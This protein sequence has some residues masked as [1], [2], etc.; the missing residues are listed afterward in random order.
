MTVTSCVLLGPVKGDES[1]A[2][3]ASLSD[4][5]EI[6]LI[7]HPADAVCTAERLRARDLVACMH[8]FSH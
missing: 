7:H 8:A 2:D 5:L 6:L 1:V 4:I 3:W